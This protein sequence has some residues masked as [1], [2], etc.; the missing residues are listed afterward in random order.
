MSK[1]GQQGPSISGHGTIVA[2]CSFTTNLVQ[3]DTS[4]SPDVFVADNPFLTAPATAAPRESVWFQYAGGLVAPLPP[5]RI[6][7]PPRR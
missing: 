2:F 3:N 7:T 6:P 1:T 4:D 5:V